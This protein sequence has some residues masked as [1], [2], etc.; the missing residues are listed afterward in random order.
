MTN[1]DIQKHAA[2]FAAARARI[3]QR[4]A[5]EEAWHAWS[6]EYGVTG[7]GARYLFEA[8][9]EIQLEAQQRRH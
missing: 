3:G 4:L 6:R 2:L 8:E 5:P 7:P 1:L 9:Y